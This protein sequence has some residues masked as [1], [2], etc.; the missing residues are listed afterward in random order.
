MDAPQAVAHCA[1]GMELALGDTRPP[2]LFLGRIIGGIIKPK[3][4]GNDEPMRRNS[5]T[6]EGL[7]ISGSTGSRRE[8]A[9]LNALID[10]F[11]ASAAP[12]ASRS[13]RTASS[14]GSRRKNGRS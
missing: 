10:R 9:R 12:P 2:R 1:A 8:R 3:A 5:P 7:V 14:G 4:L 13:I 11:V 6:V